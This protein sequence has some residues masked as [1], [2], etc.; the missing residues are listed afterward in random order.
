MPWLLPSTP[1][2]PGCAPWPRGTAAQP[3]RRAPSWRALHRARWPRGKS[4][5]LCVCP[6]ERRNADPQPPASGTRR[7]TARRPGPPSP[8]SRAA[9][10]APPR[11]PHSP[12]TA[13]SPP[14]DTPRAASKRQGS[15][16]S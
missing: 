5:L 15:P 16:G 2:P 9:A 10:A 11:H 1:S 13:S 8:R 3:P 6:A 14:C 12:S 7:P 4:C